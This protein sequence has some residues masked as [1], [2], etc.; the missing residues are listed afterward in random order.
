M[1]S[2]WAFQG[3]DGA[4]WVTLH[5]KNKESGWQAREWRY[6]EFK[7]T[8]SYQSYRIS[9]KATDGGGVSHLGQ[10]QYKE[11]P[12][13]MLPVTLTA[14]DTD[15]INNGQGFLASDVGTTNTLAGQ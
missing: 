8:A 15:S 12:E 7:N 10:M 13:E 9:F 14:S 6:Y 1:L 2:T 4:N 11:S 5:T 3:Y